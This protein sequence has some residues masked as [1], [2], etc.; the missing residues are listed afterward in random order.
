MWGEMRFVPF[1]VYRAAYS[2]RNNAALAEGTAHG[3]PRFKSPVGISVT[4]SEAV[5][6][7]VSVSGALSVAQ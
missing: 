3:W 7:S 6:Q 5:S 2:V 1:C 4:V